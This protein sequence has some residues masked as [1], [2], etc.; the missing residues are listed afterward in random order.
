MNNL[1]KRGGSIAL[2][3]KALVKKWKSLVPMETNTLPKKNSPLHGC[4]SDF[5][6]EH[7][8]VL[9]TPTKLS[10][11]TP[12]KEVKLRQKES[13]HSDTQESK[14]AR[15]QKVYRGWFA[16]YR[17]WYLHYFLLNFLHIVLYVLLYIPQHPLYLSLRLNQRLPQHLQCLCN[18]HPLIS[19]VPF[20]ISSSKFS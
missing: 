15:T 6:T 7:S 10:Q 1:R 12:K 11:V 13:N 20:V 4:K 5:P 2:L 18:L 17:Y 14:T 16:S 8:K 9:T 19:F 3:S